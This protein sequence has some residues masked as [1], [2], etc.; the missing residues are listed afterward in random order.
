MIINQVTIKSYSICNEKLSEINQYLEEVL[1]PQFHNDA[2][3]IGNFP[4]SFYYAVFAD[5][6]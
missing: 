3:V 1:R 6:Y 5:T 4:L 2:I